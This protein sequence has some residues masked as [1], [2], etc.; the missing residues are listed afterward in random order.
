MRMP[1]L[2][3]GFLA[4]AG[5]ALAA[6]AAERQPLRPTATPARSSST[7]V[8]QRQMTQRQAPI[9]TYGRYLSPARGTS[10]VATPQVPPAIVRQPAS[11]PQVEELPGPQPAPG[12]TTAPVVPVR[13]PTHAEFARGF[14]PLPGNYEAVML[15]PYSCCPV[16]ICFSHSR[17]AA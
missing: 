2:T 15:H 5:L 14:N 16:R 4:A 8:S 6:E 10:A 11:Y 13:Y 7:V 1:T 3:C 9:A 17:I 12:A